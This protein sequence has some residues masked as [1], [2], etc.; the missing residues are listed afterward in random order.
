MQR[1]FFVSYAS[2]DSDWAEWI[3]W[4]LEEAQYS[5]VLQAWDF[6]AGSNFVLE[7]ER[8]SREARKTIAVLSSAY[9]E[10]LFVKPEW[11][12]AFARDPTGVAR[13]L[14]PVRVRPCLLQGM[15]SQI[16]YIDLLN[17]D[18]RS[19]RKRLLEKIGG[20]RAKPLSSPTFPGNPDAHSPRPF[21]GSQTPQIHSSHSVLV[22]RGF[23]CA[24]LTANGL[25]DLEM[26]EN[27]YGD[28]LDSSEHGKLGK[29]SEVGLALWLPSVEYIR[30]PMQR[31]TPVAAVCTLDPERV[32]RRAC[33]ALPS[34]AEILADKL[35]RDMRNDVR[36][37]VI[38][39]M[40]Y[41]L[42]DSFVAAVTI[43]SIVLG[44]GKKDAKMGYQTILDLFLFPLLETHC[45]IGFRQFHICF[46]P[47]E[48]IAYRGSIL[49]IAKRMV[50]ALSSA[51]RGT[52]GTVEFASPNTSWLT[53]INM[54]RF[55]TWMAGAYY[56]HRNEKW[57]LLFK[58]KFESEGR[59]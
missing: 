7:M 12:A 8:A 27:P 40:G 5:T 55:L 20:E 23:V 29:R 33:E 51:R 32:L 21:P 58:E 28:A 16:I 25:L 46:P 1:D 36:E 15:L 11:A 50:A 6:S 39:A 48:D 14:L 56:N 57:L 2:A 44:V 4:Q 19:A 43:P 53:F 59:D 47:L 22:S 42:R 9:L 49:K 45:Q 31:L 54:A 41:G 13:V 18:E 24:R 26:P 38:A 17:L 37:E 3:A 35:P 52:A 30:S 10:S 34:F